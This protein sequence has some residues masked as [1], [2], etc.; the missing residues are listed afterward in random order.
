MTLKGEDYEKD[1]K[2]SASIPLITFNC[3]VGGYA[4]VCCGSK[5]F[6]SEGSSLVRNF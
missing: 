3:G 4:R 2:E 1:G 5:C 6:V